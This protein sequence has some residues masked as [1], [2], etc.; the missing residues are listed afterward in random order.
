MDLYGYCLND[1]VNWIDP[2]GLTEVE[3]F[4][5]GPYK[6]K[7][8]PGDDFHGEPHY[9]V[10]RKKNRKPI[11]KVGAESGKILEG[12]VPKKVLKILRKMG[13]I[14]GVPGVLDFIPNP[15]LI[16]PSFP[17]CHRRYDDPC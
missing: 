9:H 2:E 17:G 7:K 13:K 4:E 14:P 6:F 3:T 11:G 1:P 12:K 15:C 10:E 8:Y 5:R 16:D